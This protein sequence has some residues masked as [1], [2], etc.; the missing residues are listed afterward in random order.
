MTV[1]SRC[2]LNEQDRKKKPSKVRSGTISHVT[3][4][5][6]SGRL[7][8]GNGWIFTCEH[9][10]M[11]RPVLIGND[12]NIMPVDLYQLEITSAVLAICSDRTH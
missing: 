1:Q 2:S 11:D 9:G 3:V 4:I 6:K 10:G 5:H 8:L 7:I 12:G